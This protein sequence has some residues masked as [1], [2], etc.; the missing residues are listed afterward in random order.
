[1]KIFKGFTLAE[2]L[3]TLGILGI[4]A[5]IT[6]PVITQKIDKLITVSKLK[7][8]VATLNEII[9]LSEKDNGEVW[10]WDF[11]GTANENYD[12]NFIE[13][14][15][16]KKYFEP[17]IKIVGKCKGE[18]IQS[19]AYPIYNIDW[20]VRSTIWSWII[21]PD[22]TAIGI[23]NNPGLESEP[24]GG[25][26]MW[27]F[28]DINADKKPNM[29]GKDIFIAELVRNKR[30]VLWGSSVK[31]RDGLIN[32]KYHIYS[33]TKGTNQQYAGGYCGALIQADG[34]EIKDDYPW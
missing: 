2:V 11:P 23:F 16:F 8:S 4:I 18:N 12:R 5:A 3:I 6:L 15:F 21:L 25:Y 32:D 19:A 13:S 27:I 30:I 31:N 9:R 14:E 24:G 33:C 29:L 34:W 7:K 22:G 1:M 17:Y 28:I 10:E 20:G 26:Y